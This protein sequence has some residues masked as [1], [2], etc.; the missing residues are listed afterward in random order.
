[1]LVMV[2]FALIMVQEHSYALQLQP[3]IKKGNF[4]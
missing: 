2:D 3:V 4:G 1:M